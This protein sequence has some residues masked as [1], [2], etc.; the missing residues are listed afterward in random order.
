MIKDILRGRYLF[1]I[2]C[3]NIVIAT[4]PIATDTIAADTLATATHAITTVV[5]FSLSVFCLM[6]MSTD[7]GIFIYCASFC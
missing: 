6:C 2:K 5:K 4:G 3:L 1:K 7:S